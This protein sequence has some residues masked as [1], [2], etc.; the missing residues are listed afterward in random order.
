MSEGTIKE[1]MLPGE[2]IEVCIPGDQVKEFAEVVHQMTCDTCSPGDDPA[3]HRKFKYYMGKNVHRLEQ[4]QKRRVR[5]FQRGVEHTEAYGDYQRELVERAKKYA[6]L[7]QDG[8]PKVAETSTLLQLDFVIPS[9][10]RKMWRAAYEIINRK[11]EEAIIDQVLK[12][13]A[14]ERAYTQAVFLPLC[15][16]PFDMLPC[17]MNG[18]YLAAGAPLWLGAPDGHSMVILAQGGL[19][20][21]RVDFPG[22]DVS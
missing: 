21:T 17:G 5:D 11:H 13:R 3:L 7:D 12:F 10:N 9:K 1:K 19:T 20:V 16:W 18:S 6:E 8:R 22:I 2:E 15:G 4:E 14:A